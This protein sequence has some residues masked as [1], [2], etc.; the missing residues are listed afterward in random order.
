MTSGGED[1][2]VDE[3]E[4]D[5]ADS[6]TGAGASA[7]KDHALVRTLAPR[8]S[9]AYRMLADVSRLLATDES[10]TISHAADMSMTLRAPS[11]RVARAL[12]EYC[13]GRSGC[14]NGAPAV[15]LELDERCT[16]PR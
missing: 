4:E 5:E 9:L 6:A 2:E 1:D 11:R 12:F 16:A 14:G 3:D 10:S 15:E 13:C 7:A 8:C